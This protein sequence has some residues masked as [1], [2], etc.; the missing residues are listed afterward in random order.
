ME[1]ERIHIDVP[2][3]RYDNEHPKDKN[4]R[5]LVDDSCYFNRRLGKR[6]AKRLDAD[7]RNSK[8]TIILPA[9]NDCELYWMRSHLDDKWISY[10]N[11]KTSV[12]ITPR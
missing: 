9:K 1:R 7:L 2:Q 10:S 3:V 11:T 12:T 4:Y 5:P 8:Q 6:I